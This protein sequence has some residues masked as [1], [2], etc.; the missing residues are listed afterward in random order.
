MPLNVLENIL[1]FEKILLDIILAK[2]L[3]PVTNVDFR[4]TLDE[5]FDRALPILQALE[6][7]FKN[8]NPHNQRRNRSNDF[9]NQY[10]R[11]H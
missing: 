5:D 8:E 6:I 11:I 2:R 9:V 7:R 4:R 3:T 10:R 1:K